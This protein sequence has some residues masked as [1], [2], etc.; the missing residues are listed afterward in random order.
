MYSQST[1]VSGEANK[2]KQTNQTKGNNPREERSSKE[3]FTQ[4][5]FFQQSGNAFGRELAVRWLGNEDFP[6]KSSKNN[7][8]RRNWPEESS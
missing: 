3:L 7:V 8:I 4:V 5:I 2:R 1:L 6:R